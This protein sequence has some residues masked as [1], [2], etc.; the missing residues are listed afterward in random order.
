MIAQEVRD[1]FTAEGLDANRYGLFCSDTWWER[2]EMVEYKHLDAPRLERVIHHTPVEGA[3][4]ITQLGVR[5]DE[6]LAFVIAAM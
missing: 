6:L 5:Y 2:E 4:E 1:A 3:T